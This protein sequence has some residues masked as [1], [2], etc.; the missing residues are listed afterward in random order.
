MYTYRD[1]KVDIGVGLE[2]DPFDIDRIENHFKE[3][4]KVAEVE[5]HMKKIPLMERTPPTTE[6]MPLEEFK[7]NVGKFFKLGRRSS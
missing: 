3:Q 7:G 6:V 2:L 5:H 1:P 4:T